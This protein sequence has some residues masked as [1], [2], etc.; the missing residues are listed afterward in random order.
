MN[1]I[2]SRYKEITLK[3]IK[4]CETEVILQEP[5]GTLI[6]RFA[7]QGEVIELSGG[8]ICRV[9]RVNDDNH[10]HILKIAS[11]LYRSTELAREFQIMQHI[12]DS[13][14]G[15]LI[16]SPAA[17]QLETN[18]AYLTAEYIPGESVRERLY[19]CS[20]GAARLD[21][22]YKLGRVLSEIHKILN[23]D[24]LATEWLEEH[25]ISA[26]LNLNNGILDMEE[27]EE[28]T[29][30]ELL[31]WLNANKPKSNPVSLLHG[32]Y[33]TKNIFIDEQENY[34]VIDW[35]FWDIGDPYYDLAIIDYYFESN[36]DRESFY[37]GYGMYDYDK[38]LIE[39]YDRLSKFINV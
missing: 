37:R 20:H 33:R 36:A 30:E 1:V 23:Q 21:V 6:E 9:Y 3:H 4:S 27:F 14:H 24:H 28:Q 34:K 29:P 2:K 39:Y 25:L 5:Y 12:M 8:R 19:K 31:K 7:K 11:G 16:P 26:R 35:G 22:W 18:Y 17:F 15:Y 13:G 10:T 38:D 32:D